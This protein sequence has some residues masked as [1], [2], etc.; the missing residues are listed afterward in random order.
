MKLT[1]HEILTIP[2]L[3]SLIRLAMIP[4]AVLLYINGE[5]N[6]TAVVLLLSGLTDAADGYIARHWN[7]ISDVGK[8]LDPVADKATQAAMLLC[9][10][11]EYPAMMLPFILLV[12][13]E[14]VAAV[15]GI[16]VIRRTGR[17]PGA[18]WHGKVTT[19]MLYG[20][21]IIHMLWEDI[22]GWLSNTLNIGC[23][24][25]M[26]ISL[27]LYTQRNIALIRSMPRDK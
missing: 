12:L 13:K 5:K 24:T 25:M 23:V 6:W 26:M 2:N 8:A 10:T 20:M 1:K 21:M 17:V 16:V 27:A 15:S 4:V 9:L 14:T 19:M 18:V 22:A 7:Q 11:R 3:M